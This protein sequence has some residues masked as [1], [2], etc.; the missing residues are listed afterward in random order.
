MT[1]SPQPSAIS[2]QPSALSPQPSV[3]DR[4]EVAELAPQALDAVGP[5][6]LDQGGDGGRDDVLVEAK[7]PVGVRAGQ[8]VAEGGHGEARVGVALPAVDGVGLDDDARRPRPVPQHRALVLDRLPFK[9]ALARE[10]DNARADPVLLLEHGG[11]PDGEDHLGADA[12]E[13]DV[14]L[15]FLFFL[16]LLCFLVIAAAAA[17]AT[18]DLAED[19][20][21]AEDALARRILRVLLQGLARERD[22]GRGVPGLHGQHEGAG[23]LLAVAGP[24]VEQIRHGA[25]EGGQRDGL[26][27]RAVLAGADGVVGRD[28][29]LLEALEGSHADS[30]GGVLGGE[31]GD[32]RR[33]D[34]QV[35][36]AGRDGVADQTGRLAGGRGR[37]REVLLGRD[38]PAPVVD[39]VAG[40]ALPELG[41]QVRVLAGVGGD[42]RVPLG[43][44]G[45]AARHGG[46]EVVV[47]LVADDKVPVRVHAKG[48]LDVGDVGGPVGGAVGL[49]VAGDGAADADDGVDVDKGRPVLPTT[50]AGVVHGAD[51]GLDVP[52]AVLNVDD[53]PAAGRHLGVDILGVA[54]VDAAVAGDLVVV[55]H[56]DEVG[57]APVAGEL[58]GLHG[59]ALL[60]AGVPDHAPGH[61]VDDGE[62][63]PVVGGG[64]VLG[65]DG[66]ADGVGDALAQRARRHLDAVVL[67]LRVAGAEGVGAARV[68]RLELVHGH[69]AVARQVQEGVLEQARVAV[70][71]HEA[72]P[73]EEGRVPG[74][75]PHRVLPEGRADGRH[76]HGPARVAALVLLAQVGD[77]AAERAEGEVGLFLLGLGEGE[78]VAGRG[79]VGVGAVGVFGGHD[80]LRHGLGDSTGC[81]CVVMSGGETKKTQASKEKRENK[82]H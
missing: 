78:L 80:A 50:G 5:D 25:V 72:V 76:A 42:Q 70:G 33:A 74:R 2:P 60:Q 43:L 22:D 27:G 31:N 61:V 24:D 73:V 48:P 13:R 18:A 38:E 55:V 56:D 21:A 65:G 26:V 30:G 52:A 66:Q 3:V 67:D 20:G 41:R 37:R 9:D 44:G 29:N 63:G 32:V 4:V 57:Q 59:H 7:V 17:A 77:E 39:P 79:G 16:L 62:A 11:R 36:E 58:D 71:Q 1:L 40:D 69:V 8:R 35:V 19:V 54:E 64:E 51:D 82:W 23:R 6:V 81:H 49:C 68:V 14:G 28:V 15:L 46:A 45:V 12:D 75:V 34:H 47:D 10:A 53:V